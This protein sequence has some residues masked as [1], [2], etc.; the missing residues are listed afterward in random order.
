MA[1][2]FL[3]GSNI[4]I[5]EGTFINRDC[6]IDNFAPVTIGDRCSLGMGVMIIT[7]E[8][9]LGGHDQRASVDPAGRPVVIGNGCWV[10]ARVLILPGVRVNDGCV[11]GAGAVVVADTESDG[12]YAG[13]PA[14]RVKD[15]DAE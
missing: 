11:I 10:G 5:G 2:V 4:T 3:G 14:V 6:F 1:D 7:S 13:T 15:L 8:H 9:H 12:M